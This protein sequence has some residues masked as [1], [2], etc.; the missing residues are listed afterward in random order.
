LLRN[1]F[2][3]IYCELGSLK[4]QNCNIC[5]LWENGV[6]DCRNIMGAIAYLD[7]P[8][9]IAGDMCLAALVSAGVPLEHL[10]ETIQKLGRD[11]EVKLW[12]ELVKRGGVEATKVHVELT[13]SS[14]IHHDHAH[15]H[16][17]AHGN[18]N[19]HGAHRHLPEIEKII[20]NANLPAQV[21]EWSLAIF[22]QL[23]IAEGAVHGIPP[24][25]VHFHEVG[26]LDAIVDIV[27]TCAGL[28]WLGITELYCS[29][30]PTGGGYVNCEH[31]KMP[32]PAPATLKLWEMHGFTV[33]DNGIRKELVTPTGAA[34]A[35]TLCQQSGEVPFMTVQKVGLGAGHR[36]LEI[37]NILRLWIGESKKKV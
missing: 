8:T 20:V 7:C 33:F 22:R 21:T 32:V 10:Q 26:A 15:A 29:A 5:K 28:V 24:E 16:A 9:G 4:N 35:A 34:I 13:A 30:L 19:E 11:R 31:G 17:H 18:G 27:C 2:K 36:E 1:L 12:K 25:Q 23:A 6:I 37:P 3:K 14:H